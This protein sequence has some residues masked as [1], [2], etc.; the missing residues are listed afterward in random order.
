VSFFNFFVYKLTNMPSGYPCFF[1]RY[2]QLL[3][4]K[5]RVG[6]LSKWGILKSE[7]TS[8]K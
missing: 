1:L 2:Q 8:G 7:N 4:R 5:N 3:P 6:A